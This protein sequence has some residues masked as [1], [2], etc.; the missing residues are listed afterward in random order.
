MQASTNTNMH[1]L[2]FFLLIN[3]LLTLAATPAKIVPVLNVPHLQNVFNTAILALSSTD[4]LQ[5][6][7]KKCM[8]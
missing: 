2:Y 1:T 7:H 3:I 8:H 5:A 4:Y 6:T